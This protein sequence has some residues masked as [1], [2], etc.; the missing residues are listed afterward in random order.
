MPHPHPLRLGPLLS[1]RLD[2]VGDGVTLVLAGDFDLAGVGAF[3]EAL[4]GIGACRP[5]AVVLDLRELDFLDSSGLRA[6]YDAQVGATGYAFGVLAG[7]G[8]ASRA[9]GLSGLDQALTIVASA[10]DVP[11]A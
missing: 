7:T 5:G 4:A 6:I 11:A 10:D 2:R 9:L 8:P 1:A 3:A